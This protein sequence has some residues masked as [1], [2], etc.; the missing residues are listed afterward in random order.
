MISVRD[1]LLKLF[2]Y[3]DIVV[4]SHAVVSLGSFETYDI[5]NSVTSYSSFLP[6][7]RDI[8]SCSFA[9]CARFT[10]SLNSPMCPTK[11]PVSAGQETPSIQ[12]KSVYFPMVPWTVSILDN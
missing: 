4:D 1:F 5:T 9:H 2:T 12:R 11:S 8:L 7:W 6:S 3:C 10:E